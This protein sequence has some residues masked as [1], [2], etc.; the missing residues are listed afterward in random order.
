[1]VVGLQC[2][3][4]K[5]S[6]SYCIRHST[7]CSFLTTE[8][9]VFPAM[10]VLG[11]SQ[12]TASP[13]I[14][15]SSESASSPFSEPIT[16]SSSPSLPMR[17]F[18]LLLHYTT[19]TAQTIGRDQATCSI[20]STSVPQIALQHPFLMHGIL[21]ISALHL[22]R[23]HPEQRQEYT[24]LAAKHENIALP[25]YRSEAVNITE[26]NC[27]AVFAFSAL[28]VV[29]AMASPN[30]SGG[31][32]FSGAGGVDGL[33]EWIH[34]LRGLS[35]VLS[36]VRHWLITTPLAPLLD[37]DR[38]KQHTLDPS[39]EL[40]LS[41]LSSLFALSPYASAEKMEEIAVYQET[42][43]ILRDSF[44]TGPTSPTLPSQP[45]PYLWAILVSESYIKF[46]NERR[47]E[48]LVLL[49]YECVLLKRLEPSWFINGLA[50]RLM[51]TICE[52]LGSDWRFWIEWPL[53][54]IGFD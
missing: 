32:L 17:E 16:S 35:A 44:F 30:Q 11:S 19:S 36:S 41:A 34:L 54:E 38:L 23:L 1:V 52:N 22:A 51:G 45:S 10:S 6:C 12:R 49:A 27:A 48:A 21:A 29:Y 33:P 42:L 37:R 9:N 46:L 7:I 47:P 39:D 43:N 50:R 20:W 14:R 31:F 40:H 26:Q 53:Q 25:M 24:V 8:P 2:D 5:P 3:E 4:N 28:V 15:T 18:E 13:A